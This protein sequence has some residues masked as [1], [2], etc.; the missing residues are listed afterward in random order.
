[1]NKILDDLIE[2][3]ENMEEDELEVFLQE[4]YERAKH[5]LEEDYPSSPMEKDTCLR[6][7]L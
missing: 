4:G 6:N 1:M 3:I 7:R 2:K 5:V